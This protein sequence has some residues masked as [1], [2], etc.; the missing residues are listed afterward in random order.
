MNNFILESMISDLLICDELIEY[1]KNSDKF[2]GKIGNKDDIDTSKKKSTD[3]ILVGDIFHKYVKQL[4]V[5]AQNYIEVYPHCNNYS[6]WGISENILIQHYSPPHEGF[7]KWHTE[8]YSFESPS[9]YR[10]LVFMTYL[11]DVNDGGE[12]EFFHQNLK[13][14][15]KK[16][17]TLIWPADWTHTHRGLISKTE[18]KYVVTGWFSF[19]PKGIMI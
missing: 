18:N 5:V 19:L 15:P 11:N 14:K 2:L 6:F 7:K 4:I 8:R 3:C 17:L 13:V 1:H 12:T 9:C 16:G 10:H